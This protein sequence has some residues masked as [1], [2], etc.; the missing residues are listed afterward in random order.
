MFEVKN[1]NITIL[2]EKISE[3]SPT[4]GDTL[5][6]GF[7][8]SPTLKTY[9]YLAQS[10]INELQKKYSLNFKQFSL[11]NKK[12][13]WYSIKKAKE[14]KFVLNIGLI[15]SI[16][17]NKDHIVK[18]AKKIP[19]VL[20][21]FDDKREIF[22]NIKNNISYNDLQ[23]FRSSNFSF[24][25]KNR[26][27]ESLESVCYQIKDCK[28]LKE[29]SALVFGYA[30]PETIKKIVNICI[31]KRSKE[32]IDINITK[33]RYIW[34]L[35]TI[36]SNEET[37]YYI[38]QYEKEYSKTELYSEFLYLYK[39]PENLDGLKNLL[40]HFK[41]ASQKYKILRKC[42]LQDH[43]L[44]F[45]TKAMKEA[46]TV[47]KPRI[48]NIESL[49]YFYNNLSR[50]YGRLYLENFTW[51]FKAEYLKIISLIEKNKKFGDYQLLIPKDYHQTVLMG[52]QFEN[53][54]GNFDQID[55]YKKVL[56]ICISKNNKPILYMSI[57]NSGIFGTPLDN[58]EFKVGDLKGYKNSL[59]LKEDLDNLKS[60]FKEIEKN[61]G[62]KVSFE[63]IKSKK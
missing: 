25:L 26:K 2:F 17:E 41:D 53:C 24:D 57:S 38:T 27:K 30:S 34:F 16:L 54:A 13:N 46:F 33:I 55:H 8:H 21:L 58:N 36:L 18:V 44:K 9:G 5:F 23:F 11:E 49:T 32:D 29:L 14:E 22:H 43:V 31:L 42:D 59:P 50:N 60:F 6:F 40:S 51:E 48:D 37:F 56:P 3:E 12:T 61:T 28:N 45:F 63:D 1:Q 52:S 19:V 20:N 35:R 47:I 7:I 10:Q 62:I 15:I 39:N 4:H